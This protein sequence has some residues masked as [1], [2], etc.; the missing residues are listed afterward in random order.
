MIIILILFGSSVVIAG[1]SSH[2]HAVHSVNPE[3]KKQ[4]LAMS[5]IG[6]QWKVCKKALDEKNFKDAGIAVDTIINKSADIN[7]FK[8][9]KNRDKQQ[10]IEQSNAFREEV[11]KLTDAIKT[12][13]ADAA[14][15]A[16]NSVE[17]SCRQCHEKF[18]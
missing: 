17:E 4:H 14:E 13:D 2:K 15:S 9:H 3:M 11:I 12:G 5:T 18:R 8:L 1:T 7:N 6:K 10:F 16:S